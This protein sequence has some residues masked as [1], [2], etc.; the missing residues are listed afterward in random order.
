MALALGLV[1][2]LLGN[3]AHFPSNTGFWVLTSGWI[4][5][6]LGGIGTIFA[7]MYYNVQKWPW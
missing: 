5:I 3:V 7:W 4:L 6:V 2:L 1:L